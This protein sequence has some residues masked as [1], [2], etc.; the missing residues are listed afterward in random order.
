MKE[1]KKGEAERVRNKGDKSMRRRK[2][3]KKEGMSE[4]E[5]ENEGRVK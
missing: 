1:G 5:E 2:E 4:D 3:V